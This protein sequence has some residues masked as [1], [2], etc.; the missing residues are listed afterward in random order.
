MAIMAISNA[1]PVRNN[2]V[3]FNGR[4]NE[5]DDNS[6]SYP[7]KI[8]GM[9]TIPVVVMMTLSPSLLSAAVNNS[10]EPEEK[11]TPPTEL[12]YGDDY[13]R[14][15]VK[16]SKIISSRTFGESNINLI[17]VDG[18]DETYEEIEIVRRGNGHVTGRGIIKAITFVDACGP[19]ASIAGVALPK[20]DVNNYDVNDT[21]GNRY[22]TCMAAGDD[23]IDYIKEILASKNNATGIL[24]DGTR[25]LKFVRNNLKNE[26]ASYKALH[27]L[28]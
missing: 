26:I 1:L 10:V 14:T 9:K 25:G 16:N 22:L 23:M 20:E 3:A 7:Q 5:V 27:G 13:V 17:S 19:A 2:N 11:W 24:C 6:V 15:N 4:K 21:V 8:S 28:E 18:D 12:Y